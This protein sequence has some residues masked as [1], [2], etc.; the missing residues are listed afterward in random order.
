MR[1]QFEHWYSR[2]H[3][4]PPFPWQIEL[5]KRIENGMP[6]GEVTVPTGAGKTTIIAVWLWA[7]E[8]GISVPTRLV[9]VIDRQ[10]LV[11][12]ATMY[13]E[14]LADKVQCSCN[15]IKMR[16]G[17]TIDNAWL[18]AP[19]VPSIIVST[20]DQVGS[21]LLFRGYGVSGSVAPIHA[22]LLA[23][24]A[25]IVLDEAHI[26]SPF[27]DTLC[28]INALRVRESKPWFITA[29][30]ATPRAEGKALALSEADLAN[31][32]LRRRL[33]AQKLAKL[34]KVTSDHFVSEMVAQ[35]RALRADHIPVIGIICNTTRD[36]R[37]VF[38]RLGNTEKA[39]LTGRI[40][41][42]ERTAILE[43][44]L[45]LIANGSRPESDPLGREP[46]YVVT[47]QT[48]EVGADLDF[49]A[50]V[51]QSAPLDAIRQ[52]F[53]RLDRA[54]AL[55][56]SRAVIV[57]KDLGANEEC[58][59]YGKAL[60]KHTWA[61]LS[62]S[63][64][65]KGKAKA[66]DFGILA[67]ADAM[68][69]LPAPVREYVRAEKVTGG[70][71]RKLRQTE[72]PIPVDIS[73]LLHGEQQDQTVVSLVWRN[74]LGEDIKLWPAIASAVMPTMGEVMSCPLAAV[75]RW[76]GQR[77]VVA[78][79]RVMSARDLRPGDTIILPSRYGGYDEWGWNPVS[80][81]A[82]ADVGNQYS[83][84]VRLVSN[85]ESEDD[86]HKR[87]AMAG[88]SHI[89]DPVAVPYPA[90][91]LV[92][93]ANKQRRGREV[94][95]D[96]HSRGVAD[97]ARTFTS[98]ETVIEAALHHDDGKRDPRMQLR[99]GARGDVLA[100]SGHVSAAARQQAEK[101]CG[102]PAG[103]RHE[104]NSAAMLPDDASELLRY[105]VATHHGYGRT[106]LPLAGDES[107]W[108]RLDGCCWGGLSKRL[109]EEHG[110]WG[111][112]YLEALVRLA[113]WEQ[114]RKEQTDDS[115]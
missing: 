23:N 62:K 67:I 96:V 55:G 33:E 43:K 22:A 78:R 48:I 98:D 35:A 49:D 101:F 86:L 32:V 26:S 89:T 57:H 70:L 99:L 82:V 108:N 72:P 113:D 28:E 65:G 3:G 16:G 21:R 4:L 18:M 27:L 11:D 66:V 100:K 9:Y 52:R 44:Y 79:N 51:T 102:L 58:H 104:F 112:A 69:K 90:G 110:V 84:V 60:L 29:M 20:V 45:P 54:G 106:V 97:V 15:V 39:L 94:L 25:Y 2:I 8:Q 5:A 80:K 85:D 93:D 115:L 19:N 10:L 30:T 73:T 87:L 111:L 105:L 61:W 103:W 76:L 24:D 12:S 83:K 13:A 59:I 114:S 88:L 40:R 42:S 36:A 56:L 34:V 38:H 92:R 50:L 75:R 37:E 41:Q 53:G 7:H 31:P 14:F 109:N 77:M 17:I 91:L 64:T 1:E 74:D 6:P 107:M 71:L 95:L 81:V 63:Q 46:I 47:T 68:K